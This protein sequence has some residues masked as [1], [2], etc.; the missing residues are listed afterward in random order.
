[1]LCRIAANGEAAGV[2]AAD[3]STKIINSVTIGAGLAPVCV[4][5]V[6][7]TGCRIIPITRLLQRLVK[8]TA[9]AIKRTVKTIGDIP[10]KIGEST[11][12]KKAETPVLSLVSTLPSRIAATMIKYA[13]QLKLVAMTCGISKTLFPLIRIAPRTA[14]IR[15]ARPRLL[16]ERNAIPGKVGKRLG[17]SMPRIRITKLMPMTFCL[18]S[19]GGSGFLFSISTS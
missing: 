15:R 13:P 5:Y 6:T 18:G 12:L 3:N 9:I 19:I 14:T 10:W 1:M 7:I 8:R 4:Q 16:E 2:I 11:T 17:R